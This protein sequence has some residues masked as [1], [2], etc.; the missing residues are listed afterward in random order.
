M[1]L[2]SYELLGTA[3]LRQHDI[4]CCHSCSMAMTRALLAAP[5]WLM[6]TDIQQMNQQEDRLAEVSS[7]TK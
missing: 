3:V 2:S 5:Q 1:I 6:R 7:A 4:P